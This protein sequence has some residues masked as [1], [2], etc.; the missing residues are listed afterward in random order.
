MLI[1]QDELA[2]EDDGVLQ[3]VNLSSLVREFEMESGSENLSILSLADDQ[4]SV[5]SQSLNGEASHNSSAVD[6]ENRF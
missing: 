2:E 5:F 4:E 1:F 3:G 6:L